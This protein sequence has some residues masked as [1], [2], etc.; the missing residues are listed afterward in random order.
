MKKNNYFSKRTTILGLLVLSFGSISFAQQTIVN[1]GNFS[2]FPGAKIGVFGDIK[3][4]S[5]FQSTGGEVHFVGTTLQ[6]ISGNKAVNIHDVIVNNAAHIKLDNQLTVGNTLIF[7][8]GKINSDRADHASQYVHFLAGSSYSGAD[9]TKFIDGVARKTGNTA[10]SFPVGSGADMQPLSINAP[11][12]LL[13]SYTVYY[14]RMDTGNFTYNPFAVDASVNNVSKCENWIIDAAS[15]TMDVPITLNYDLNSC[16]VG[17]ITNQSELVVARWDGSVWSSIGNYSTTGTITDGTVA[18]GIACSGCGALLP[19]T[20]GSTTG[21]NPLPIELLSF[22]VSATSRKVDIL[23][24]TATEHNSDFFTVQKTIDGL[25]FQDVA[26]VTAAGNSDAL[27][28]YAT[29]DFFPFQGISYYRLKQTNIDGSFIYTPLRSVKYEGESVVQFYPN[30]SATNNM[31]VRS[32][33]SIDR[34]EIYEVNGK[35]VY[36]KSDLGTSFQ[37]KLD[38]G[39]YFA[40]YTKNGVQETRKIIFID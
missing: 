14:E 31:T 39:I 27:L 5:T 20:I 16:G 12:T 2:V 34:L 40:K 26:N 11:A 13:K 35:L 6:T 7:T 17:S 18:Q 33:E 25:N 4:D 37:I 21:N 23:W 10:F 30:P 15:G 22:D 8:N 19:V 38:T 28:N 1:K 3:N 32:N 9:N 24:S 29:E 36:D